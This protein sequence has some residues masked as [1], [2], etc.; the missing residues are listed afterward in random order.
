MGSRSSQP[1]EGRGDDGE[2][3]TEG[4][5]MLFGLPKDR[6]AVPFATLVTSQFIL[7]IGVGALLPA[8]PLYAQSIGLDGVANGIVLSAP[9]LAMLA[10]NLP[11]GRLVDSWG[12]KQMMMAGMFL[13]ACSD[14][15]TSQCRTVAALVPARLSLGAGRAAAENGDRAYLANLADR[16]PSAR[17]TLSGT[18]QAVQALG[19]VIGPLVGGYAA[20]LYGPTS[21]FYLIAAAALVCTGG[22]GLLPEINGAAEEEERRI[23]LSMDMSEEEEEE[24][25]RELEAVKA[26][27]DWRVLLRSNRQRVITFAAGANALGFV[28]KLTCIPWFA[29]SALGASPAEVGELFSL[30]ALLGMASAPLGGVVADKIGLK[31]VMVFSLAA[32][33]IGLGLAQ[34]ASDVR[35]LQLYIG[36]W[37]MGTAAAGP[38]VNA[39]AQESAP[40][41]GEGE[42]LTLPKTAG[43]LVFLVGPPLLGWTDDFL[44]SP[45][46]SLWLV[47]GSAALAAAATLVFLMPLAEEENV[48]EAAAGSQ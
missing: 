30:T 39:L 6:V 32:C 20:E 34:E 23:E 12:R 7:F 18:Q 31:A 24:F 22:Y 9:A 17:G 15:A 19:L 11:A 25:Q 35:Q 40:K 33:A 38:A 2:D 4:E 45:G 29:T 42:A 41:G 8:L 13:I 26:A 28:A 37:G 5:E 1:G 10:L 16:F 3:E 14:L 27:C 46:S 47:S 44:G 21:V 43:D 36:L 48:E